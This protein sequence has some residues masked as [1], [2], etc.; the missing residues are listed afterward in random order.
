MTDKKN[1]VEKVF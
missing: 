1:S